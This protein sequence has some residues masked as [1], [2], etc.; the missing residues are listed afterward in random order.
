MPLCEHENPD[1]C[2]NHGKQVSRFQNPMDLQS[3]RQRI[4]HDRSNPIY[5]LAAEAAGHQGYVVDVL[6][7]RL[8]AILPVIITAIA[9]D[10]EE[11]NERRGI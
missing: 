11:E 9:T 2:P 3:V 6:S 7:Q 8:K 1:E 4:V 10:I 5:S